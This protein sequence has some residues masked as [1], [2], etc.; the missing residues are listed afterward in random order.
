MAEP[1]ERV[2]I[3][4]KLRTLVEAEHLKRYVWAASQASGS[5]LDVACG[6]GYGSALLARSGTVSGLDKDAGALALARQRTPAGYFRECVLPSIPFA[7]ATF[8]AVVTFETIEHIEDDST[9]IAEIRRVLKP[10]GTLLIST[11]NA[12]VSSPDRQPSNPF[13]IREY[14]LD[15]FRALLGEFG[16]VEVFMQGAVRHDIPAR[17]AQRVKA[18]FPQLARP[19]ILWD[20]FAYSDGSVE[21]WA[22]EAPWYW[23]LRA[24]R[25][26]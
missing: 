2:D 11:P 6:T 25:V 22:G 9:Y 21:T 3:A 14:T 7:T 23:L 4:G 20:R 15:E 17:I 18:R 13:H 12:A 1:V 24:T 10:R 19:S 16:N 5:I 26:D 8:D